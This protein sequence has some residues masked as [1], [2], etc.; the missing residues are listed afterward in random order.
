MGIAR[1]IEG[2]HR[3]LRDRILL[4]LFATLIVDAIG[5]S[6][7]YGFERGT[8][9]SEIATLGDSIFWTSCQLLTV[10]SQLKAPLSTEGRIVDVFLELYA[11]TVVTTL[12]G[13]WGAFF[14]YQT[15]KRW[16]GQQ[17]ST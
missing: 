9:G 6:L 10:S 11:I 13:S 14:H 3:D 15:R 5:I 16:E 2:P 1:G 8:T 17:R 12:A 7:V 4:V